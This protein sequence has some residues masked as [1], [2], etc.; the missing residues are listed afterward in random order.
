MRWLLLVSVVMMAAC[1]S[2]AKERE[3]A[4][5]AA[6]QA[7]KEEALASERRALQAQKRA[8][9]AEQAAS[10]SAREAEGTAQAR[11]QAQAA[12]DEANKPRAGRVTVTVTATFDATKAD[13]KAWDLGGG[14]RPEPLLAA[15]VG[16]NGK[17]FNFA[18]GDDTSTATASW[19][20]DLAASDSIVI[21]ASDKDLTSND[22]AGSFTADFGGRAATRSGRGGAVSF[23]VKFS[24][25]R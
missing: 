17:V 19:D 8:M 9:E 3:A 12:V 16:S 13:G 25:P 4:A 10:D 18:G 11:D 6:V 20:M 5:Q 23:T 1:N 7:A 24:A 22:P 15:R 14:S 21:T 2:G